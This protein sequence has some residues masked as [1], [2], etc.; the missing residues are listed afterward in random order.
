VRFDR[1]LSDVRTAEDGLAQESSMNKSAKV[2]LFA[3]SEVAK[4]R[5]V[6]PQ[7]RSS[8]FQHFHSVPA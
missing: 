7:P 6:A 5:S 2:V 3:V 1:R 4:F 8:P